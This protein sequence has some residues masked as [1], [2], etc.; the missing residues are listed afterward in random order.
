[1]IENGMLVVIASK[2]IDFSVKNWKIKLF[3]LKNWKIVGR[4][5]YK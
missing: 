3:Q 4:D 5:T 2:K 1:M